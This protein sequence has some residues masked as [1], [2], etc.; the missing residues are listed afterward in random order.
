MKWI[1]NIISG[2]NFYLKLAIFATGVVTGIEASLRQLLAQV[3]LLLV[4]FAFEPVLYRLIL[5]SLRRVLPFFA[6][7]WL[8]ATLLQQDF[9]ITV[10]FS[11]QLIY[12]LLITVAVM[13]RVSMLRVAA[14]SY[15][16]RKLG[17]VNS[18][19]YYL[20]ATWLF[21]QSFF[22]QYQIR[23]REVSS[24]PVVSLLEAVIKSVSAETEAI[25]TQL[26]EILASDD[27][28]VHLFI[29]ANVCGILFLALLIIVNGL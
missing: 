29:P 15:N 28:E 18:A 9:P 26:R 8:F 24:E 11:I 6:A 14:E 16:V 21:V 22:R 5:S 12:L 13:G 10:Q 27:H 23:Q 2:Q 4:F 3:L 1:Q 17:W 7:Y 25:R 19:F 20:F